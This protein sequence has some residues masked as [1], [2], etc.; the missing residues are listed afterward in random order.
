VKHYLVLYLFLFFLITALNAQVPLSLPNIQESQ[1]IIPVQINLKPIYLLAEKN[2]DTVFTSPN[3]PNDWVQVDCGTRYKYHF[4]RSPLQLKSSGSTMH[5]SFTGFYQIIG[6]SRACV[7]GTALSPWTPDCSC[8]FK[9]GERKVNVNFTSVIAIQPN[10]QVRVTVARNQP[11]PVDKCTVCFWG[12]DITGEVMKGLVAELD[13]AKKAIE[14][15][16]RVVNTRPYMQEAWN[17]LKQVYAIPGLGY[18]ALHPKKLHMENIYAKD[19][20][21]NISLGITATPVIS[22]DRPPTASVPVPDI[23][24]SGNKKGFSI[25]LDAALNYDSLST[26][27]NQT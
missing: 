8:G 14:D 6:A 27:M 22:F 24:S 21:L 1:I 12:Q 16:F 9:E 5:L 25:F 2:V 3:Y 15:S 17:K 7:K 18:L 19:D 23:S 10:H 13:A 4:R 26:V 11:Q 20:L